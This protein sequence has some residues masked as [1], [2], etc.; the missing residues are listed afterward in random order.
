MLNLFV[1]LVVLGAIFRFLAEFPL[2]INA[3]RIAWGLWLGAFLIWGL[4]E[5]VSGP[6]RLSLSP[7]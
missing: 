7:S 1:I 3:G 4:S 6:I 5:F 2:S